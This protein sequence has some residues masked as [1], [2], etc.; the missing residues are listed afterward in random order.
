MNLPLLCVVLPLAALLFIVAVRW[1]HSVYYRSPRERDI[2]WGGFNTNRLVAAW[3]L[4][5][6]LSS[7]G[8]LLTFYL[9][10][11]FKGDAD[12]FP[13]FLFGAVNITY[14]VFL[15]VVDND[16]YSRVHVVQVCLIVNAVLYLMIF[17]YTYMTFGLDDKDVSNATLLGVT[18]FCNAVAIFHAWVMDGFLWF[19]GWEHAISQ[20][21]SFP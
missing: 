9:H 1:I 19:G 17:M 3:C 7:I 2:V 8:G 5:Y 10:V 21:E 16:G 15:L 13:V 4:T 20:L 14:I 12:L 18:H 6:V 11:V